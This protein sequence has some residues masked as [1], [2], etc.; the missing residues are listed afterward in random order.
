MVSGY[1]HGTTRCPRPDGPR[2]RGPSG[3]GQRV[4]PCPYPDTIGFLD[5]A[6]Y[7]ISAGAAPRYIAPG[8]RRKML[9]QLAAFVAAARSGGRGWRLLPAQV[10]Q[11]AIQALLDTPG[12]VDADTR[13]LLSIELDNLYT[14]TGQA[15]R[16]RE[17]LTYLTAVV[18]TEQDTLTLGTAQR[19]MI[20]VASSLIDVGD[21]T[22]AL[23]LLVAEHA[24]LVAEVGDDDAVALGAQHNVAAAQKAA[25]LLVEATATYEDLLRR[26][27][28]MDPLPRADIRSTRRDLAEV[29]TDRGR[30]ADARDALQLL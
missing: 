28:A 26:R 8:Q 10:R 7:R 24:R 23:R 16:R 29:L 1:G 12:A 13:G 25:G 22:A 6:G 4:V 20:T 18:T 17:L 5:T 11:A 30:A 2:R 19:L 9:E 3:R 27:L 14:D 15:Q 21:T